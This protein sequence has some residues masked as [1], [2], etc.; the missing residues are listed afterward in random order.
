M[1]VDENSG[2]V[3]GVIGILID[4]CMDILSGF[5]AIL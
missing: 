5:L 2:A 4:S 1:I 3:K